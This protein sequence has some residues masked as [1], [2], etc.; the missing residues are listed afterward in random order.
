MFFKYI[1]F[2][3]HPVVSKVTLFQN[4]QHATEAYLAADC[5]GPQHFLC[6]G[7]II[8]IFLF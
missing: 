2:F 1:S 4:N 6:E 7:Q 3:S 5:P 8:R